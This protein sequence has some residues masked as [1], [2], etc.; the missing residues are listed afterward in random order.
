MTSASVSG[1][2]VSSSSAHRRT[3]RSTTLN[4]KYVKKPGKTA[5]ATANTEAAAVDSVA[6]RR[7][8]DLKRR[9]ALAEKINRERLATLRSGKSLAQ[10]PTAQTAP[11]SVPVAPKPLSATIEKSLVSGKTT[12]NESAAKNIKDSAVQDALKSVATMEEEKPTAAISTKG[13]K[14]GVKRF[15]LALACAA[16][17][18]GVA[19]Y[20]VST[21][22]PDL[23]VKV[24]AMQSGIDASYPGYV[25]RGYSL[26]DI[27][28]E[29]GKL[30]M[31]FS[32]SSEN[33]SFILSEEKSAWDNETLETNYVKKEFGTNYTSVREQGITIYISG[34][35][36]AWVNGGIVYK[37]DASGNNLTKKQIKTIVTSL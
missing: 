5:V 34:S 6:K 26:S 32:S 10:A 27:L 24:A 14:V 35:D 9:Q 13:S 2:G 30:T 33:A 11:A 23:S 17:V 3:Q 1:S 37:L 20:Y 8:E 36:A 15:A 12:A 31:T 4:R 19:S 21:S 28:S 18:V 22:T 16:V 29:E 25:P 7:A